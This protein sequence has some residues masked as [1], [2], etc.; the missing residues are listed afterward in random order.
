MN[1]IPCITDATKINAASCV[2]N[3]VPDGCVNVCAG[4]E[5]CGVGWIVKK[6]WE[7]FPQSHERER[8]QCDV[9]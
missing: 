7:G 4:E 3:K 6:A 2:G 5:D 1:T 8:E 9:M